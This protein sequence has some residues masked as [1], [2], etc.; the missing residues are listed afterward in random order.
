MLMTMGLQDAEVNATY[1]VLFSGR[2]MLLAVVIVLI[3][4]LKINEIH[5]LTQIFPEYDS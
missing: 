3:S 5:A 4:H 2:L 1:P